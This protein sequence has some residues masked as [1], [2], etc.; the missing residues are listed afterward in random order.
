M[1][2]LRKLAKASPARCIG[3]DTSECDKT[4][5]VNSYSYSSSKSL[6]REWQWTKRYPVPLEILRYLN[7]FVDK[8]CL[9]RST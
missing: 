6:T 4:L 3:I 5:T 8:F 7:Y 2:R 9:K 1:F